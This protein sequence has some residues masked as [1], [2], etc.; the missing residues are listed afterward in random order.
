MMVSSPRFRPA[1]TNAASPLRAANSF[2][3]VAQV[4]ASV[5]LCY[6]A[7]SK[8]SNTGSR[9]GVFRNISLRRLRQS[10]ERRGGRLVAGLDG[11]CFRHAGFAAASAASHHSV[12][13]VTLS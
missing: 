8:L 12:G 9:Y 13:L 10:E 7:Q 11:T 3:Q 6:L 2:S 4:E 1:F 5:S